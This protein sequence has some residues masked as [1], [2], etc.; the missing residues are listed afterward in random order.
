VKLKNPWEVNLGLGLQ[1]KI[2]EVIIYGGPV[3]Y[4][5]KFKAEWTGTV[6][7]VVTETASITL[8]E[9]NNIGGFAGLRILLSK[10]LNLEVEGQYKS[11]FSMG[12]SLTY[13]F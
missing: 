1:V 13:A 4:W 7:G 12:G 5:T 10:S 3:A 11:E 6:P 8:K 2:S 9:K